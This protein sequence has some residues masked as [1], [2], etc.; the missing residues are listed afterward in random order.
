MPWFHHFAH[1]F[2]RICVCTYTFLGT[3][4]GGMAAQ[5]VGLLLTEVQGGWWKL[6][7]WRTNWRGALR[8]GFYALAFVWT[9]TFA[10]C[11]VTTIYDDHRALSDRLRAAVNEN[12][13]LKSGLQNNSGENRDIQARRDIQGNLSQF[14]K[15]GNDLRDAWQ[16]VRGKPEDIQR[17]HAADVRKWHTRLEDFLR[18]I[19]RGSIYLARLNSARTTGSG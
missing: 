14:M 10:I 3:S 13:H 1:L 8:R 15:N 19:P 16:K 6:S 11:V 18:T 5:V 9:V 7:T 2:V 17:P 4:P 12:N